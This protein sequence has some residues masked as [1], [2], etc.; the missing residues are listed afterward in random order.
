MVQQ[1][2]AALQNSHGCR[3]TPRT[4]LLVPLQDL[5]QALGYTLSA[6]L[7]AF[8]VCSALRLLLR[9]VAGKWSLQR[10]VAN[11]V[12]TVCQA[13]ASS[14]NVS[15]SNAAHHCHLLSWCSCSA[16]IQHFYSVYSLSSL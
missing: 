2:A 5:L 4:V 3:A 8:Q 9:M 11:K 16:C 7:A 10:T 6:N 15:P 12:V 1:S 13:N 14:A